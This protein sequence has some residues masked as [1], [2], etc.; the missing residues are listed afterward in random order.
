MFGVGAN[1]YPVV[2]DQYVTSEF[3]HEFLYTVHN[4]YLLVWAETGIGGLIAFICFFIKTIRQGLQCCKLEDRGL[5]A[6]G[7]GLTA[8]VVGYMAHMSVD[9]FRGRP[10]TQL[11]WFVGGLITAMHDMQGEG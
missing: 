2:I 1:N 6:L 5:S 11:V 8:G 4:Q 3:S 10:L 9:L 7:F